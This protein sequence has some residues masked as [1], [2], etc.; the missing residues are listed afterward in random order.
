MYVGIP[1]LEI[2]RELAIVS[3][4]TS[5]LLLG[6]DSY[7]A[8]HSTAH[9]AF[10]L[11]LENFTLD[12]IGDS[13]DRFESTRSALEQHVILPPLSIVSFFFLIINRWQLLP[14][15]PTLATARSPA[16]FSRWASSSAITLRKTILAAAAL[17]MRFRWLA[18]VRGADWRYGD[19][20]AGTLNLG[21]QPPRGTQLASLYGISHLRSDA[22]IEEIIEGVAHSGFSNTLSPVAPSLTLDDPI[23]AKLRARIV[24][25]RSSLRAVRHHHAAPFVDRSL[26]AC[27][28]HSMRH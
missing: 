17:S 12:N 26:T 23:T 14:Y 18:E 13:L 24:L 22:T 8:Q 1:V 25:N 27:R 11:A 15:L 21:T 2:Q 28:H 7:L 3:L 6:R 16:A 19:L 4:Y 5:F 20:S 10:H 9:P